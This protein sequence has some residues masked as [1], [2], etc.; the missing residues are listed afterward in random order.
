MKS[1]LR[2]GLVA[3]FIGTLS[4]GYGVGS[5]EAAHFKE[6]TSHGIAYMTG[7]VG[8]DERADMARTARDFNLKLVF[9]EPSRPYLADVRVEIRDKSGTKLVDT[10]SD[11]PW[12]FARLPDG[13]YQVIV[14]HA[15][16]KE[17]RTVD[18]GVALQTL[19]FLWK[20]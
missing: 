4:L 15:G 1:A 18:A 2:V 14:D 7:G 17:E 8:A 19:T 11:G 16:K 20:A 10:S 6:G 12:F 3:L 9:A 13:Q 5:A